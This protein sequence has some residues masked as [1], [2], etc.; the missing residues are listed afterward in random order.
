M[1]WMVVHLFSESHGQEGPHTKR[2]NIHERH[3]TSLTSQRAGQASA[4]VTFTEDMQ[5]TIKK[6]QFLAN[7]TK[8]QKFINMLGDQ[9]ENSKCKVHHAPGDADLLIVQKAVESDAIVN[10]V[11]VGDDTD[12]LILLCYH[13]SLDSHS[14]FFQPEPKKTT[15]DIQVVLEQLGPEVCSNILFQHAV[16]GCDTTSR[17]YGIGKGTSLKKFK[18]SIHFREL[19]RAFDV[20]SASTDDVIA[21]GEQVLVSMGDTGKTLTPY[22]ISN[23]VERSLPIPVMFSLRLYHPHQLQR[24]ITASVYTFRYGSGKAPGMI[25]LL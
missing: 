8:K 17:L 25:F 22:A 9:L 23:S 24:N 15:K 21:A 10:T 11:L 12:L 6:E 1:F 20:Q 2:W 4:T 18:S 19:A 5:L 16:L 14:I 7:K 13:A 3:D